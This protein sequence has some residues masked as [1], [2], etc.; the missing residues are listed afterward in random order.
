MYPRP[1]CRLRLFGDLK[2]S[3]PDRLPRLPWGTGGMRGPEE[4]SEPEGARD[5]R[6]DI[7]GMVEDNDRAFKASQGDCDNRCARSWIMSLQI[8]RE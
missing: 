1:E 2:S 5:L 8:A 7:M 3:P 6:C 4:S